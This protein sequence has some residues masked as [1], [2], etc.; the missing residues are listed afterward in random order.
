MRRNSLTQ[1]PRQLLWPIERRSGELVRAH[2]FEDTVASQKG[3][4]RA[5]LGTGQQLPGCRQVGP[6]RKAG[7]NALLGRQR[8]RGLFR[9]GVGHLK[10]ALPQRG[11]AL[12][13]WNQSSEGSSEGW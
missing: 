4:R 13:P 3:N 8:S 5:R 7:E 2:R 6:G 10:F 9:F 1:A 12:E 11:A